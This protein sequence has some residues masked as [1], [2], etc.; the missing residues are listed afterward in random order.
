MSSP[1][2]DETDL[3][4]IRPLPAVT[5][6]SLFVCLENCSSYSSCSTYK[7]ALMRFIFEHFVAFVTD[8]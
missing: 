4:L 6:K 7:Y 3:T 8:F 5:L 2:L 1:R